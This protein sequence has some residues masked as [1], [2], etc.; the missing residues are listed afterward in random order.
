MG[1]A[2]GGGLAA[3]DRTERTGRMVTPDYSGILGSF[4]ADARAR[5][6]AGKVANEAQRLS[7]AKGLINK[8]GVRDVGG[9]LSKVQQYGL[10][11]ADLQGAADN[12]WSELKA[13]DFQKQRA[14]Q[15]A[16][17]NTAARGMYRSGSSIG[18]KEDIDRQHAHER[19]RRSPSRRSVI[20]RRGMFGQQEWER[21]QRDAMEQQIA[22]QQASLASAYQ[23]YWQYD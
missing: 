14:W 21:Q 15:N 5:F 19:G 9:L 12:P 22:A 2:G 20:C 11:Q 8:L 13:L 16:V 18:Q 7:R 6:G 10:S 23:P 4:T 3:G 17:A 1:Y